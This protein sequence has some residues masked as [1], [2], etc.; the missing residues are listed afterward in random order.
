V[1]GLVSG[2]ELPVLEQEKV[3]VSRG[4]SRTVL[5]AGRYA[6]K[7]PSAHHGWRN[8]LYGLLGNM[9]ERAFSEIGS[10]LLC[11]VLFS[12]PGGWLNVMP[13]CRVMTEVEFQNFDYFGF[14]KQKE[15]YVP[16][17]R[18]SDSFG[19]LRGRVVAIDYGS[20]GD[21]AYLCARP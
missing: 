14:V 6:I 11:P 19:W 3:K 13:R 21:Y 9:Q 20:P 10:P 17:E 16:A 7:V 15:W 18:K 8:F 12:V 5:L 2:R 1:Q 4:I